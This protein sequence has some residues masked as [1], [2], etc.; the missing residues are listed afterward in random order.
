MGNTD[1]TIS[2]EGENK[3][4]ST[5]SSLQDATQ[6][7]GDEGLREYIQA[8]D[9]IKAPAG[10][11]ALY[12]YEE[13]IRANANDLFE[14]IR[15]AYH[16][17]DPAWRQEG[18]KRARKF[19]SFDKARKNFR[20]ADFID[21]V[22][23]STLSDAAVDDE[24]KSDETEH[25]QVEAA[26]T[27]SEMADY[28][29]FHPCLCD[30]A[31]LNFLCIVLNQVQS[32]R[33]TVTGTFVKL[34]KEANL[35]LLVEAAVGDILQSCFKTTNFRKPSDEEPDKLAQWSEDI[36]AL[37]HCAFTLGK[38]IRHGH[39]CMV[40][41]RIIIEVFDYA[42][43]TS[44]EEQRPDMLGLLTRMSQLFYW[45]LRQSKDL[46]ET[47]CEVPQRGRTSIMC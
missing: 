20:E 9:S 26:K 22:L 18:I 13:L 37:S 28:D 1:S 39:G 23:L 2:S 29:D 32:G 3:V 15:F 24:G 5:L 21:A 42:L 33:E 16:H 14:V 31:V 8:W 43:D 46:S 34:A 19:F 41:K 35:V 4:Q 27:I 6:K 17:D 36:P 47:L 40:E 7:N 38:L 12:P 45:I 11:G 25:E 44:S 10:K 30:T